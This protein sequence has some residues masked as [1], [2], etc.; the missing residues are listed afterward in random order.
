ME[1]FH[2]RHA[3]GIDNTI[4]NITLDRP[5]TG[6]EFRKAL[7]LVILFFILRRR[8]WNLIIVNGHCNNFLFEYCRRF[9]ILTDVIWL[10][11]LTCQLIININILT[12]ESVHTEPPSSIAR[13]DSAGRPVKVE[14][15]SLPCVKLQY[16]PYCKY[17]LRHCSNFALAVAQY[18]LLYCRRRT[19]STRWI[20]PWRSPAPSLS[21]TCWMIAGWQSADICPRI[22]LWSLRRGM[23]SMGT[24]SRCPYMSTTG[25]GRLVQPLANPALGLCPRRRRA[26]S[27]TCRRIQHWLDL[28]RRHPGKV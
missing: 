27:P 22:S 18:W 2:G 20:S 28:W 14:Q 9:W 16:W 8:I 21:A 5:E 17:R 3:T 4:M 19:L 25:K 23:A 10:P 13:P 15:R 12:S 26:P 11:R 24:R 6:R 7:V 1:C